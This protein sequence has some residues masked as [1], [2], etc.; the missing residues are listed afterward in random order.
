MVY[1]DKFR[2]VSNKTRHCNINLGE[3]QQ[4]EQFFYYQVGNYGITIWYSC[5]S[6]C[7]VILCVCTELKFDMQLSSQFN[8]VSYIMLGIADCST[9]KFQL[10][11]HTGVIIYLPCKNVQVNKAISCVLTCT[12]YHEYCCET[13]S[14]KIHNYMNLSN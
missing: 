9:I 2:P 5:H 10:S 3:L 12:F 7:P 11:I 8:K 6:L 14:A 13:M 4:N 1:T